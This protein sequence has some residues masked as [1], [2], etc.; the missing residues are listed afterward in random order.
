MGENTTE[1]VRESYDRIAHAYA[2]HYANELEH[3]PFDRELLDRFATEVKA[4]G[5]VCDIGCGPGHVAGYLRKAGVKVFGIDLSPG[6]IEQA[7]KL[8]PEISFQVGD[9]MALDLADQTLAGIV[10]FYAIVNIPESSLL[11]VFREMWRV[12]RP[13]GRLLISFH[14]GDE[15]VHPAELLGEPIA[16]DFFFFQPLSITKHLQ[17][18][19]F[20]IEHVVEREPYSPNVEYQSQRAYIFASKREFEARPAASDP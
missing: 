15:I 5:D 1:S 18:A 3:K 7:R 19:R 16:I 2:R 6:M 4:E 14:I 8:N 13:G 12:L 11:T 9:M 17:E 20:A 10:G